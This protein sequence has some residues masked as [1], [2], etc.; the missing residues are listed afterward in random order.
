M[1]TYLVELRKERKETQQDVAN[2]IGI[3]RQYYQMIEGGERQKRMDIVLASKLAEHFER[4]VG[5]IIQQEDD[6]A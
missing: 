3:T 1:R 2:A 5:Y 4:P 6:T